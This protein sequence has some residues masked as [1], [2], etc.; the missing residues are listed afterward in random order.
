[1]D[2][3]VAA[4]ELEVQKRR[5]YDI[6][7]VLEGID[8][9]MKTIKNKVKWIGGNIEDLDYIRSQVNAAAVSQFS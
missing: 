4:V 6:T 3:N 2:L 7:N 1:V 9:I 8:L 5:I